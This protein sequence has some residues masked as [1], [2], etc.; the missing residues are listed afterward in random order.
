MY[1]AYRG[2]V[3]RRL[4][5]PR[6]LGALLLAALVAVACYH[7]G[8]WQY[9]RH[10]AKAQRNERLDAHYRAAPVPLSSALTAAGLD[11]DDE[12]TRVTVTGRY[13]GGP[14][15]VRG[16]SRA[17][18]GS[19]CLGPAPDRR[20]PGRRRRPGVGGRVTGRGERAALGRACAGGEVE[21]V[22]WVRRGQ[23]SQEPPCPPARS[24]TSTSVTRRRAGIEAVLP[25]YLLLE[26]ETLPDGTTAPRPRALGDPDR[27]LGPHLAYA[28]QWWLTMGSASCSCGSASAAS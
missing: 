15:F 23:A 20:R 21:V 9:H 2:H 17:R 25:G 16:R 8:W 10:E 1:V 22:G 28:Y 7:L 11:P 3:L 5:T 24:R 12:W 26:S 18:P 6:W 14:V 4:V 27:G 13:A 19:R